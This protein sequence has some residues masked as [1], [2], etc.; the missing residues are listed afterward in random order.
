MSSFDSKISEIHPKTRVGW[1]SWLK[2]NHAKSDGVWLIYY[3]ASTG[4]R[5]LTWE[6][7]V[8]EA[9]CFGWID[10]KV[11]PID[12]ARYKQ[13]FTPRKPRSVWSKVNKQHIAELTHADLMTAAGLRAV[14]IAKKNG[15]WSLLEPVDALIVPED[16]ESALRRSKRA[17][18]AYESLSTAGKR[19][20]LYSLYSAKR[21][22]TRAK[23]VSEAV[24]TLES[25]E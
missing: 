7:A 20:V 24:S 1:R 3:R 15:A 23:R 17:R 6:D 14:D 4:K 11:K 22:D 18:E 16:L 10:S 2:E 12:D 9:L 5:R 13:I 25:D 19:S 8:R 21:E